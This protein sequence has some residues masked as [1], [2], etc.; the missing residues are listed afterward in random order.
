MPLKIHLVNANNH[1]R[2]SCTTRATIAD[3]PYNVLQYLDHK[4]IDTALADM[5]I[6]AAATQLSS[7]YRIDPI[8]RFIHLMTNLP[9]RNNHTESTYL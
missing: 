1:C 6:Y 8:W 5:D 2:R 3:G 9:P 4:V 7:I